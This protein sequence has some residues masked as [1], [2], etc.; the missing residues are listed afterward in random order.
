MTKC[1]VCNRT[2]PLPREIASHSRGRPMGVEQTVSP[3][4]L[5]TNHTQHWTSHAHSFP[6]QPGAQKGAHVKHYGAQGWAPPCLAIPTFPPA[7]SNL[8]SCSFSLLKSLCLSIQ[9]CGHTELIKGKNSK[10]LSRIKN[11][12]NI[13]KKNQTSTI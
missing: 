8:P 7:L 4:P 9:I 6:W 12:H 1:K 13:A 2:F 10:S 5:S 3:H 11:K